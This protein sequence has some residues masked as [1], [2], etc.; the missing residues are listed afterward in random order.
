MGSFSCALFLASY[1]KS[2]SLHLD[3]NITSYYVNIM[4]IFILYDIYIY[5]GE[6]RS[7]FGKCLCYWKINFEVF[8]LFIQHINV[9]Q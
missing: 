3:H 6:E 1:K 7:F 8:F 2:F 9:N 4:A 5:D